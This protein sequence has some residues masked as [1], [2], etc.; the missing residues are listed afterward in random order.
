[1][2]VTFSR[3]TGSVVLSRHV[4][5]W[6]ELKVPLRWVAL[7]CF[8]AQQWAHIWSHP[9]EAFCT[10]LFFRCDSGVGGQALVVRVIT[11][12]LLS[13]A[14]AQHRPHDRCARDSSPHFLLPRSS[15]TEL[16]IPRWQQRLA[17]T[18]LQ[19]PQ[20]PFN[21]RVSSFL[22]GHRDKYPCFVVGL[23]NQFINDIAV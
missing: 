20:T 15:L 18:V 17:H 19:V 21:D 11:T 2:S 5:M 9:C 16:D 7:I 3:P 22:Y 10:V 6:N 1:M 12:K 13:V 8:L 23:Q 4:A 14:R